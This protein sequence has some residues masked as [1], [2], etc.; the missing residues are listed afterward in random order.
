MEKSNKILEELK[1]EYDKYGMETVE[2]KY[3]HLYS[4][5]YQ[6]ILDEE[7]LINEN[8]LLKEEISKNKISESECFVCDTDC[9]KKVIYSEE[10]KNIVDT[11][12]A[13]SLDLDAE[14]EILDSG[15]FVSFLLKSFITTYALN[16]EL[17]CNIYSYLRSIGYTFIET[18]K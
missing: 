10:I 12:I 5:Y 2:S 14:I 18:N 7:K 4:L 1:K 6:K 11:C 8:K 15:I 9:C 16:T 3:L 17:Y 13:K